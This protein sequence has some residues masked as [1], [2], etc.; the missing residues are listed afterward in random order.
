MAKV[1][2]Y[3]LIGGAAGFGYSAVQGLR[4]DEPTEEI[5]ANAAKFGGGVAAAGAVVGLFASR[6]ARRKDRRTRAVDALKAGS[7]V[8]AARIARPAVE[9][10]LETARARASE[11]AEA[12]RPRIEHA[13]EVARERAS[14]A[15]DAARPRV[16]K[17]VKQTRKQAKKAAKDAR[18]RY[19]KAVKQ[20][21]RQMKK[22]RKQAEKTAAQARERARET[23]KKAAERSRELVASASES[24]NGREPIVVKVA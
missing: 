21:R 4:S 5:M 1:L 17:A 15:A 16:E 10:A 24:M 13:A 11:A 7:I 14:E 20:S 18:P 6:R 23:G 12:A 9:A 3:A 22:T 8:E 19:E 2:K